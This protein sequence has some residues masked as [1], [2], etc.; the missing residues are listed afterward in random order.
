MVSLWISGPLAAPKPSTPSTQPGSS[1]PLDLPLTSFPQALPQSAKPPA[2]PQSCRLGA[3]PW[4]SGP[5][6]SPWYIVFSAPHGSPSLPAHS[7]SVGYQVLPRPSISA[8]SWPLPPSALPW[9]HSLSSPPGSCPSQFHTHLQNPFREGWS[10]VTNRSCY[11]VFYFEILLCF[12]LFLL[13]RSFLLFPWLLKKT[14][15]LMFMFVTIVT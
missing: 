10:T 2:P 4:T 1:F 8:P 7:L 12:L 6:M 11:V 5:S 13:P 3:P 15:L 14:W 9:N